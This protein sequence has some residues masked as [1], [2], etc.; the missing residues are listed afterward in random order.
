MSIFRCDSCHQNFQNSKELQEH[1]SNGG[2]AEGKITCPHCPE[3][4]PTYRELGCHITS[5]RNDKLQCDYCAKL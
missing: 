5:H 3:R 2:R 4:Y 1:Q